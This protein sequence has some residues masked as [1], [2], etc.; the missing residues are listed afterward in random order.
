MLLLVLALIVFGWAE[1][2]RSEASWT[3]RPRWNGRVWVELVAAGH[4]RRV[5][6]FPHQPRPASV[7][8]AAGFETP[9]NLPER[10]IPDGTMMVV[11]ATP[12]GPE[13][14]PLSGRTALALGRK[15]DLNQASERDLSLLPGL[16]PVSARR[17]AADRMRRGPFSSPDD[18][19]RVR[20][21]GPRSVRKVRPWVTVSAGR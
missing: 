13:F 14:R 8:A 12:T 18:L 15:M 20:G 16:G 5:L 17:I 4:G 19:V 21:I 11:H 3:G 10:R 7:M 6:A 2:L 1:S 9:L